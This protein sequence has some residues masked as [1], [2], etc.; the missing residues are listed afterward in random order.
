MKLYC[1]E[2]AE[3]AV[4]CGADWNG[5][6]NAELFISD[7][8]GSMDDSLLDISCEDDDCLLVEWWC[9]DVAST[10]AECTRSTAIPLTPLDCSSGTDHCQVCR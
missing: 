7:P 9:P 8:T 5:V 3:C 4:E 1:P 10:T 2:E 6:C